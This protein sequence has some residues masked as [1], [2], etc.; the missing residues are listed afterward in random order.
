MMRKLRTHLFLQGAEPNRGLLAQSVE[1]EEVMSKGLGGTPIYRT[2][3]D[4]K[5]ACTSWHIMPHG[6]TVAIKI[7]GMLRIRRPTMLSNPTTNIGQ[8]IDGVCYCRQV[9]LY[10]HV[11]ESGWLHNRH[12]GLYWFRTGVP[13]FIWEWRSL[14]SLC[15]VRDGQ[16][17]RR[18]LELAR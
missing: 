10:D 6:I 15:V 18:S 3:T 17:A 14:C 4:H 7:R 2:M 5:T 12:Q 1:D 16:K 9:N 8:N 13:T 11:P